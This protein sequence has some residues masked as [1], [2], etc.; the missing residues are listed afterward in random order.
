MTSVVL[1]TGAPGAGKSS[2]LDALCTLL[3]VEGI[4]HGAIESEQL[5]RGFPPLSNAVLAEQLAAP[6]ELQRAAGRRLFLIAF[7]AERNGEIEAVLRAAGAEGHLVA[8][9][10]A[11]AELLADRL[12]RREP[13]DWP[14]KA[15]LIEHARE[16]AAAAPGLKGIDLILDTAGRDAGSVAREL[17]EAMRERG[18]AGR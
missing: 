14:G 9:L 17:L 6:L 10:A 2:V 5:T 3:E 11:P 7:T 4:E 12:A 8:C 15:G 1:I 18:L 13:D 16:L